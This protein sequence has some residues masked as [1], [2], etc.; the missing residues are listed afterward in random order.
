MLFGR[1]GVAVKSEQ[2]PV[3]QIKLPAILGSD[4]LLIEGRTI[5]CLEFKNPGRI[6]G[7]DI[8][9]W[10]QGREPEECLAHGRL[11]GSGPVAVAVAYT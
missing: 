10:R 8:W 5:W 7:R 2:L 6:R 9:R 1:I 11:S 3:F 4:M